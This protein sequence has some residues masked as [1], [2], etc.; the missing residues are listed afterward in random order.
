MLHVVRQR[1]RERERQKE[2]K[3][4]RK[5]GRKEGRKERRKERKKETKKQRKP[6]RH[7]GRQ[8]ARKGEAIAC[9]EFFPRDMWDVLSVGFAK[10]LHK[11]PRHYVEGLTPRGSLCIRPQ[12]KK[13]EHA[14]ACLQI[15]Q[16]PDFSKRYVGRCKFYWGPGRYGM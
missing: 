9:L 12:N 10:H 3:K 16:P 7:A 5:Q 8:T 2:R 1:L 6:G 4:E 15:F 13:W 14:T 11:D